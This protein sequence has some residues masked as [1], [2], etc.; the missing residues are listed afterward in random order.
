[1]LLLIVLAISSLVYG[2][3]AVTPAL[4]DIAK[5]FPDKSRETIQMIA[6]VPALMIMV[7][8]LVCGQL[9]RR[10][11]KKT[12]VLT[13]MILYAIGGLLPAFF[14]GMPFIL[15][16]RGVYGAGCGFL[17]PLS[18]SLIAD[19]F[20]GR[21][22]DI[23]MG[24]RSSVAAIFGM[25]FTTVGGYLCA[26]YWR[27]T[28]FAYL[29]VIP[30]FILVL[31]RMP[32]PEKTPAQGTDSKGEL[33]STMWFFVAMYFLFNVF[34]MCYHTNA[35]FV[36]SAARV[37]SARTIG[38]IMTISN[39]GG[40]VAGLLLGRI[41]QMCKRFT[42]VVALGFLAFGF[43]LLNVAN[44]ALTFA[45]SCAIWGFGFGTFIPGIALKIIGSVPKSAATRALAI[46]SC[47]LGIGQFVSPRVYAYA[48][49]LLGLKGPRA[50]WTVAAFCFTAAFLV[51]LVA[52]LKETWTP[53]DMEAS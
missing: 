46:L 47:A 17:I 22:R 51:S 9:S 38:L 37:G 13:G 18:Q 49:Y 20:Q 32:E 41:T 10:M 45:V 33:T 16:M 11:R 8:T 7:S 40:I 53:T 29:L 28:F 30:V 19:F 48:N 1:M 43:I 26:I 42:L 34:M 27:N 15:I 52:T 50:S 14:G 24:Y 2:A 44:T 3:G 35:S 5:V 39:I 31:F 4:A 23:F 25:F 12:L 6:T 21:D 36:M